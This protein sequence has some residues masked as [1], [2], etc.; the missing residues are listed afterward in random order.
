M[1]LAPDL[2]TICIWESSRMHPPIR[3]ERQLRPSLVQIPMPFL[4]RATSSRLE[5]LRATASF[6][7]ARRAPMLDL[8]LLIG[9]ALVC[10]V[11]VYERLTNRL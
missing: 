6:L 9:F 10:L 3:Q 5:F 8:A 1:V 7:R 4:C 2:H 11:I